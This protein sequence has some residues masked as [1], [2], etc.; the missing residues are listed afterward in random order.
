MKIEFCDFRYDEGFRGRKN[1]QL[2]PTLTTHSTG[3]SGNPLVKNS[4][5]AR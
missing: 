5:G 2:C 3:I 4:G 1:N